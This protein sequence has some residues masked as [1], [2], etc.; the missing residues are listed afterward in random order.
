M[1]PRS[2][3]EAALWH[4]QNYGQSYSQRLNGQQGYQPRQA[5]QQ[6]EAYQQPYGYGGGNQ[7]FHG[8]VDDE[9]IHSGSGGFGDGR[10]NRGGGCR[11]TWWCMLEDTTHTPSS[12]TSREL[13]VSLSA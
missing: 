7:A 2:M 13:K 11:N 9:S 12:Q 4:Q 10:S 1:I 6:Q 5:Y 8:F 3:Q